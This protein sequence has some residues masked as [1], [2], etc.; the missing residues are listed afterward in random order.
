MPIETQKSSDSRA[1]PYVT[2]CN[3]FLYLSWTHR[4]GSKDFK[5]PL[6]FQCRERLTAQAYAHWLAGGALHGCKVA[7]RRGGALTIRSLSY[8]TRTD[9]YW[10]STSIHQSTM[11]SWLDPREHLSFVAGG[12]V[13]EVSPRPFGYSTTVWRPGV[14][15]LCMVLTANG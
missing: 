4:G 14:L 1:F 5:K 6:H 3:P 7:L 2:Q 10:L 8:Q 13:K 12:A 15:E 9:R 11:H